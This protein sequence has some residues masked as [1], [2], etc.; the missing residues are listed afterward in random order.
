MGEKEVW[1]CVCG[2]SV[3]VKST[4]CGTCGRDRYGVPRKWVKPA[5]AVRL[6]DGKI[7]LL[8]AQFPEAAG[9]PN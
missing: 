1:M 2:E 7:S 8:R 6:L 3:D 5:D 4:E 9:L